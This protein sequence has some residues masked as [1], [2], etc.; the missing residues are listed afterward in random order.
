ML[1]C[2]R[3]TSRPLVVACEKD[4]LDSV[5]A[6]IEGHDVEKT[7]MSMDQ[8]VSKKGKDSD[9]HS[10]TPLQSAVGNEQFEIVQYLVKTFTKVDLIGQT[11]WYGLSSVHYAARYSTKNVQ[12]LQFL[13]DNYNGNI[14]EIINQKDNVGCTPLDFA[15]TYND[16]PIKNDIVALLR[17]YGGKAN[18]YDKNGKWK[19][20]GKGDLND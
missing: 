9:G 4:D 13:I 14:E 2:L 6:L 17:K 3:Q 12:M 19:G 11:N 20:N 15:Y 18:F 8:M 5:K 10:R 7:G 1:R 16:S